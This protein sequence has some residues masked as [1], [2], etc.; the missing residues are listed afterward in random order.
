MELS[1]VVVGLC[2]NSTSAS[3]LIGMAMYRIFISIQIRL[4]LDYV[5]AHK[6][7]LAW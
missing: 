2:S 7:P 4:R 5:D 3:L 6:H 1:F